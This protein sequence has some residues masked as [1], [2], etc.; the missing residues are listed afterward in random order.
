MEVTN[1]ASY[2]GSRGIFKKLD[3]LHE[4][5]GIAPATRTPGT[6]IE[7]GAPGICRNLSR[8]TYQKFEKGE[9]KPGTPANP[10][11]HN[12]MAIAQVPNITLDEL[13]PAEWPDLRAK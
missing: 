7:P 12:I 5:G 4:T 13:L 3:S 8:Y 9:S 2:H 10:S 6:R 1:L 11:L